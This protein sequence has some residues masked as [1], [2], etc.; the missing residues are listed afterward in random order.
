MLKVINVPLLLVSALYCGVSIFLFHRYGVKI[1]ND[2]ERYLVYANDLKHGFYFDNHNFWYIGYV[3]FIFIIQLFYKGLLA[4]VFTQ[5]F[6]SFIAVI[7][8][9]KTALLLFNNTRSAVISSVSYILFFEIPTWN[10]YILCESLYCSLTCISLY[11]L[12][13]SYSR[14]GRVY[15]Y[16]LTAMVICITA[17]TKPTGIALIGAVLT[18]VFVSFWKSHKNTPVRIALVLI[19]STTFLLVVN[20]MLFTYQVMENYQLGEIIYAITS[21]PHNKLNSLLI[22]DPPKDVYIPSP[23]NPPLVRI[24]IFILNN[25]LY[26][27]KL[28]SSK[29]FYFIFHIRPYWSWTHNLF[30]LLFLLPFYFYSLRALAKNNVRPEIKIFA[31]T[32]VLIHCASIG[33]TSEDWDG[34]FLMPLLP[35]IFLLGASEIPVTFIKVFGR[36]G[37]A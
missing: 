33:V 28:F 19:L 36:F 29:L 6:L 7:A 37:K 25:P 11:L 24:V 2:S 18:I 20:R 34:R 27:L 35:V 12:T 16:L 1:V 9:Y 22:I 30:S 17:L 26:F 8:L 13:L 5:Y 31:A 15:L 32:Y 4:I 10:S 23:N 14:P 21:L 3:L